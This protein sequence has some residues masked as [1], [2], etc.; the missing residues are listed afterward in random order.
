MEALAGLWAGAGLDAEA[1]ERVR[2]TGAEPVLPSSFAVGIAAQTSIAAAGLAAAEFHRLRG[3]PAQRVS[4]DMRHAGAEFRSERYV[5]V[6]GMAAPDPWDP[7]AGL[8]PTADGWVRLHTNFAHLRAGVVRLLGCADERG[9]V[10]AALL[11]WRAEAFE[12][13]AAEAGMCVTA[14][15]SFTRFDAHPQG[16]ALAAQPVISIERIG[17]APA[18]LAPAADRPLAGIRVLDLTRIIAGPVCGRTLAAHGAEV[19]LIT[20]PHLPAIPSL[21]IDTGRGKRAAQLDLRTAD[22]RAC[23]AELVRGA[24]VFVQGYRPGGLAACGFGPADTAR[25]RPG[26]VHVSLS[27]WGPDG[28]WAGRRGFDSLTQTASG[29]NVAEAEA[30]GETKPRAL[31]AQALDPASG[32]LCALGATAALH[33]RAREGGSW[34]V[35][36]SLARTG[37]WIRSLG[38]IDG[39]G[40]ADPGFED[41]RDLMEESASGFGRLSGVRHAAILSATPARWALPPVPLGTHAPSWT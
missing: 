8:Y 37:Q 14:L 1:L 18:E 5:R 23:L 30:A 15:R 27:A 28:P 31:P 22:G 26:I 29:F 20:G 38:R 41:V 24:D 33:R 21:V 12:S 6:D 36:V 9:A 16:I 2:L 25:L 3:G 32:Y 4:V 13:A 10:A 35:Q 40:C 17:D 19:L 11:G 7:I 39:F 34:H